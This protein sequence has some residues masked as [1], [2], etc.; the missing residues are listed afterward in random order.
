MPIIFLLIPRGGNAPSCPPSA[1]VHGIGRTKI[2]YSESQAAILHAYII[3]SG[4]RAQVSL[5]SYR[6]ILTISNDMSSRLD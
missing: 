2:V 5:D 3:W 1:D 6:L 4:N